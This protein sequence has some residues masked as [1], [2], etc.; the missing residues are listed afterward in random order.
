MKVAVAFTV[1]IDPEAWE[2]N[3]GI[4]ANDRSALRLDV[5]RY[6]ENGVAD[7]LRELGLLIEATA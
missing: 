3:Y 4:D 5:R 1:D 2:A 7:H 6:V